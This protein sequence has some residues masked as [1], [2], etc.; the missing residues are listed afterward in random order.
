MNFVNV[1]ILRAKFKLLF[2]SQNFY[3]FI[4]KPNME[5]E[6]ESTKLLKIL[7]QTEHNKVLLE[8]LA[9]L[10]AIQGFLIKN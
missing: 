4:K 2:F 9:R 8:S 1:L 7:F 5:N 6:F 3:L 10:K